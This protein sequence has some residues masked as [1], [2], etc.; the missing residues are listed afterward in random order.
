MIEVSGRELMVGD[1]IKGFKWEPAPSRPKIW[2]DSPPHRVT[3]VDDKCVRVDWY[4]CSQLNSCPW[5]SWLEGEIR[6]RIERTE[7]LACTA[8]VQAPVRVENALGQPGLVGHWRSCSYIGCAR[9][10][11]DTKGEI[12][13]IGWGKHDGFAYCTPHLEAATLASAVAAGPK[14][15]GSFHV[16]L[17]G[18]PTN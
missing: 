6:V 18:E 4:D 7:D 15:A 8:V 5:H 16:V 14:P 17:T 12:P 11:F 1:V 10:Y 13:P 9:Q 3:D 2:I